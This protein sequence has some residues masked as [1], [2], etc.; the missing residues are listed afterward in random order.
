MNWLNYHHLLYFWT[1]ARHGGLAKAADNLRLSPSTVSTQIGRLEETLGHKLFE[2]RGRN[3]VLTEAGQ[4]VYRHAE[5]IFLLGREIVESLR[6][7]PAKRSLLFHVGVAGVIPKLLAGKFLMPALLLSDDIRLI[8]H[9]GR[10]DRLIAEL[11]IHNLDV[12]LTDTPLDSSIRVRAYNHLLGETEIMLFAAEELARKYR[13]NFPASLRNAPFLLPSSETVL[14]GILTDWFEA[15]HI[16]PRIAAEFDDSAL[17]KIFGQQGLGVFAS[18]AAIRADI[19][20][21]Y[22]VRAIG[23]VKGHS[24][25]FYAITTERRLRHPAVAAIVEAARSRILG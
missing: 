24:E 1:V 15:H 21:L 2:R 12:V 14:R 8:C 5:E 22:A 20:K 25:R 19:E 16:R 4:V 11:S 3:L 10:S 13:R 18:P 7:R 23:P 9:E 17:L 6:D